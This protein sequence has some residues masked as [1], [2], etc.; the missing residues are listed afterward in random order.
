[1]LRKSL[2]ACFVLFAI[3]ASVLNAQDVF[4][5]PGSASAA[6]SALAYSANPLSQITGVSTGQGAFLVLAAAKKFY[7]VQNS[8]SVGVTDGTFATVR[9][10]GSFSQA[11]TGAVITPDGKRLAVAAGTL[12]FFDTSSDTE[13]SSSAGVS[14]GSGIRVSNVIVSLDGTTFY[15][16][17]TNSAGAS[18][19]SSIDAATLNVTGSLAIQGTATFATVGRNGL[20]YVGTQNPN[21]ILEINPGTLIVTPGGTITLAAAPNFMAFTADGLY[22]LVSYGVGSASLVSSIALANH[23]IV[24]GIPF[25]TIGSPINSMQVIGSAAV[26]AYS[27]GSQGLYEILVGTDG[28]L[29]ITTFPGISTGVTAIATS[30]EVPAGS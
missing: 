18:S 25:S 11:P 2:V 21:Q 17:G 6:Q 14:V 8:L 3:V 23:S 19:L 16:L 4:A 29:S 5:L 15:C 22:A 7:I 26:A 27:N 9:S 28:T 12:H 13:L 30:N 10:I 1:M 20:V 24:N